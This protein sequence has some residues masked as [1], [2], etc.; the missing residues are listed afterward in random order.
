MNDPIAD[1]LNSINNAENVAKTSCTLNYSKLLVNILKIL[2]NEGYIRQYKI[3]DKNSH[4]QIVVYLSGKINKCKVIKPRYAV[5]H[6]D[7]EKFEKSFLISRGIGKII[8]STTQG[9][10][11]HTEAKEKGLGGRLVAYVY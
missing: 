10:M 9:L 8:V 3:V 2:K 7:Y 1:A 5:K 11:T 4:K 6:D